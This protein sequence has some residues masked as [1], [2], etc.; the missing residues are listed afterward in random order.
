MGCFRFRTCSSSSW[1]EIDVTH[2][3]GSVQ[4]RGAFPCDE[5]QG[6]GM[7]TSI[8]VA[9]HGVL[10]TMFW[11]HEVGPS[12]SLNAGSGSEQRAPLMG[13]SAKDAG[14]AMRREPHLADESLCAEPEPVGPGTPSSS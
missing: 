6:E 14:I 7:R 10:D 8:W 5:V 4:G 2:D 1:R 3:P 12:P 9:L 13:D 11:V